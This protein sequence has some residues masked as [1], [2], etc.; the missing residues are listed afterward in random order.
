[1]ATEAF[2]IK[3]FV[4]QMMKP[5]RGI[6]E[7]GQAAV[8][9]VFKV[10]VDGQVTVIGVVG[11]AGEAEKDGVAKMLRE[12][13]EQPETACVVFLSDSYEKI[14]GQGEEIEARLRNVAGRRE[15]IAAGVSARGA[16]P[17]FATWGYDR[18]KSGKP[19]FDAEVK[20]DWGSAS[21]RFFIETRVSPQN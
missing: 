14:Y 13:V 20:W 7:S 5:M 8:P 12:L 18:D 21:G 2:D 4:E 10:G 6:I 17:S 3:E 15:T 1:M 9:I 16:K 19:V 11:M